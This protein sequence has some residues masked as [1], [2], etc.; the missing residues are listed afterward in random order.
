VVFTSPTIPQSILPPQETY[1]DAT[2]NPN[3]RRRR[4]RKTASA[5]LPASAQ[6]ETAPTTTTAIPT[7]IPASFPIPPHIYRQSNSRNRGVTIAA[8]TLMAMSLHPTTKIASQPI[9]HANAVTDPIT[10]ASLEYR[11]LL[12]GPD[13]AL[14]EQGWANEFR[15]LGPHGTSTM[16]A[17]PFTSIPRGHAIGNIRVVAAFKPLKEE[18]HR[19]HFTLAH[20]NHDYIGEVST[21]TVEMPTVKCHL[22]SVVSTPNAST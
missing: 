20:H 16:E 19:V 7:P 10:G 2:T 14:W 1:A 22:N 21:P 15:R 9:Y 4:Q 8:S 18:K 11:A 5:I 17:I 3:Q 13:A 6:L 12:K